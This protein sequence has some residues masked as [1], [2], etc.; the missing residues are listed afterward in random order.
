MTPHGIEFFPMRK[1]ITYP[2]SVNLKELEDGDETF[3]FSR[4]SGELNSALQDLVK[5]HAYDVELHLRP[6]G[7]AFEISGH[8]STQMDLI[9]ARCGRDMIE[10]IKDDFN[11][12]I[13]VMKE[14][15]RAG[16]SGHTGGELSD[17]PFCNYLTSYQFNLADFI[18]EHIAA[19]EPHTPHCS[20][21]DCETHLKQLQETLGL[22]AEDQPTSP[23]EVLKNL[24]VKSQRG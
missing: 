5:N 18:H 20:R 13:V 24:S 9:C 11:E 6:M 22:A 12:L 8:I 2:T 15:P 4:E 16:H 3:H 14:K 7:N 19:V 21:S 23:F 10:P 17:G 1:K